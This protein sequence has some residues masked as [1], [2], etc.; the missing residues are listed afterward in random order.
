[1]VIYRLLRVKAMVCVNFRF[2]AQLNYFLTPPRRQ[3]WFRFQPEDSSSIKNMIEALGVPHAEVHLILVNG[4]SVDFS[5]FVR[6]GDQ[7]SVYPAFTSLDV[8]SVSSITPQP[9]DEI[10]FVLD[11]HLG[12]LAAY[13]RMLG[14]DTVYQ[15]KD[16]GDEELARI[17]SAEH[18]IL[19]TRDLGL[20]KRSIVTH[21]YYV[22]DTDPQRQ[23]AEIVKAFKLSAVTIPFHRCLTCNALLE[24]V[25]K[26]TISAELTDKTKQFFDEFHRCTACRKIYWKGSHYE[27][28]QR[29]IGEV[30]DGEN[31]GSISTLE[32]RND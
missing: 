4:E 16:Y 20:L 26:E 10:K 12:R 1:M 5:Y 22:R 7:I 9:L 14:F 27:R 23:L 8:S 18:R 25:D 17:S 29:L 6:D 24:K 15:G 13:L 30:F 2:Y 31:N 3:T 28:M 21:G 11:I 19:L 32:D